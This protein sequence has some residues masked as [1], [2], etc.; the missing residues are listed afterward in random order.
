MAA[1][2]CNV[3]TGFHPASLIKSCGKIKK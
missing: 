3:A 2:L 1:V